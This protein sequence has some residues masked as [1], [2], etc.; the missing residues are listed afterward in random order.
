[1]KSILH[2]AMVEAARLTRAGQ[3]AAASR[4]I[5]GLLRVDVTT[6]AASEPGAENPPPRLPFTIEA[7]ADRTD[8]PAA[9]ASQAESL[10]TAAET[11]RPMDADAPTGS[12]SSDRLR[13][14]SSDIGKGLQN[15][16]SPMP[17]R[18]SGP[19]PPWPEGARFLT[20]HFENR[21]G[22][23]NYRL[24]IPSSYRGEA[25]PLLV[26][27]HGCTQSVEDFAAGTRMNMVAEE[28]GCLVAYPEQ[29]KS[30]N[31]SKCWN[32]FKPADQQRGSGEPSLIAGITQQIARDFA[33]DQRRIYVAG[34][35]AGGATAAI[36]GAAYP[37]I[38]AAV[39]VH[40]GLAV[41]AASDLPSALAAMRQGNAAAAGRLGSGAILPIIVFHGDSDSTVHPANGA[42]IIE[43]A[44]SSRLSGLRPVAQRG[45]APG[46]HA[47]S[48]TCYLDAQD[49]AV[50][51]LWI[52]HTAGHAWSGGSQTGSYTDPHGPDASREM[53][54]FFFDH[55]LQAG[56]SP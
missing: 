17:R 32:W 11:T 2:P 37:D 42:H 26:M 31:L 30:A 20:A 50:M 45:Q 56:P 9:Q 12:T 14:P 36:V 29:A 23:R 3:L 16:A 6:G 27:L 40:S 38:Y 48:R 46:G 41:G 25:A 10:E 18:P 5:L 39:G 1:M 21:A 22:S 15:G 24:Y 55:A 34:L 49:Q 54:R 8:D 35:S 43:Q 33:V 13:D 51:E 47:Y 4:L 19:L 53:V 7:T 52:V 44:K 28:R